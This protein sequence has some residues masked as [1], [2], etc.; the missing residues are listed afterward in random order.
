[1]KVLLLDQIAKV[2]YKYS[3]SLAQALSDSGTDIEMAIDLKQEDE[4]VSV[5]RYRLFN[6]DEKNVGKIKKMINYISSYR[7]RKSVV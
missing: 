4:G 2:N 3:Y 6:T 1:M 7:D 5:K